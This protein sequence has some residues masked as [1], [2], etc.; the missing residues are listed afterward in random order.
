M[1]TK[2][3]GFTKQTKRKLQCFN[4]VFDLFQQASGAECFVL[5]INA[6][7]VKEKK[8]LKF[9]ISKDFSS[10]QFSVLHKH[11]QLEVSRWQWR[12]VTWYL[13]IRYHFFSSHNIQQQGFLVGYWFMMREGERNSESGGSFKN[14]YNWRSMK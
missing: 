11:T 3:S 10:N 1:T 4:R 5:I 6:L 9:P 14:S 2:K 12:L 7:N 8:D 13:K